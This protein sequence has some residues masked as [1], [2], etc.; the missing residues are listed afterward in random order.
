[1]G[2]NVGSCSATAHQ[3][4]TGDAHCQ[5]PHCPYCDPG[6]TCV[7]RNQACF[8][9]GTIERAGA[10]GIPDRTTASVFCFDASAISAFGLVAGLPGPGAVTRHETTLTVGFEP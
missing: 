1:V 6:E 2:P 7:F 9:N 4:C 5:H 3:S 8:V 10:P